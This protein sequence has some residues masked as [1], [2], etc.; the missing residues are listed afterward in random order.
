MVRAPVLAVLVVLWA[1]C[2][3]GG[4]TVADDLVAPL[5]DEG[6][7]DAVEALDVVEALDPVEAV[8]EV[9]PDAP[10]EVGPYTPVASLAFG[11]PGPWAKPIEDYIAVGDAK[12][13]KWYMKGIHDLQVWDD[14][15]YL[16]YGDATANMGREIPIEIRAFASPD[17]PTATSEFA[18]D[19][20]HIERYRPLAGGL[21][22]AGI[23]AVEDAWLGNVYGRDPAGP[24]TKRRTLDQGVHVHDV[25]WFDGAFWACGSGSKAEEWN[26][27]D[28]YGLL[29]RSADGGETFDVVARVHN[30]GAG[31]SRLVRLLPVAD[32]LSAFGYRSDAQGQINHL[33]NS[34]WDG[35]GL[36][37]LPATHPL[38]YVFATESDVL[39]DGS[40][41]LRG[42]DA[43]K[44]PLLSRAWRVPA[45]GD[46][47]V[48]EGLA[49]LTVVDAYV[50]GPTGELLVL[51]VDGDD[52]VAYPKLT[53]WSVRLMVTSDLTTW[54]DLVAFTTD[55]PPKSLAWWRGALYYG[56]DRGE[57][58]RA[59]GIP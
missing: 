38:K 43:S 26:A 45:T 33:T 32:T 55:V 13:G 8:A 24:W 19:E 27:G 17:D 34:T 7:T 42:V 40:G 16:G 51:A 49:G 22:I 4:G 9:A 36:V 59:V 53:S 25:A 5:A 50:N 23:D 15:L 28:I 10:G 52:Y 31:D 57:I 18:T 46:A 14:R 29:W 30:L 3:G 58:L 35:S 1:A 21:F 2:G 20:E 11:V 48:V 56:T 41:L 44:T 39:P 54:T 12:Y 6:D 47:A 37:E